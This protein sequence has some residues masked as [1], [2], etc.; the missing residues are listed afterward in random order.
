[1]YLTNS[2]EALAFDPLRLAGRS[3]LTKVVFVLAGTL[4]LAIASQIAVPMVPVPITMQTFAVTMIGVLY[5]WRLG[6][7]TVLAWLGEAMLGAPVLAGG[8]GGIAPF[9]GAT[10]GYL[11]SFPLVA[12]AAGWLAEQGWT[13]QRLVASFS[14]H[15][16]ANLL[17]LALGWVWLAALIGAE[18][19]FWAGVAPFILGAAL[20]SG[21]AAAVLAVLASRNRTAAE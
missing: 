13:G 3:V 4:A 14:A 15:L 7:V 18:K 5:G 8:A 2:H 11:F 10:A 19:A 9:M 6:V 16:A 1:M 20:K 12:A 21:L 17:C